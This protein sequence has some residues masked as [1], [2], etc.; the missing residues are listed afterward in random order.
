[1]KEGESTADLLAERQKP[2]Y[3]FFAGVKLPK[4]VVKPPQPLQLQSSRV[5][6]TGLR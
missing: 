6:A 2:N 5:T 3:K 1:L 4:A